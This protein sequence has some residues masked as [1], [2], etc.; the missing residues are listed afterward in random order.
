MLILKEFCQI[1]VNE[2]SVFFCHFCK[3]DNFCDVLFGSLEGIGSSLSGRN[4]LLWEQEL[5]QVMKG[6]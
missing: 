4:L 1:K 5:V 3:G 2:Y 6:S